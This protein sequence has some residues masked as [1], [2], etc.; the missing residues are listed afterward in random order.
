L[1]VTRDWRGLH[2]LRE[3]AAASFLR[4]D[5]DGAGF[6]VSSQS[7]VVL[8]RTVD[9]M[10]AERFLRQRRPATGRGD[11][12]TSWVFRAGEGE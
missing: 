10:E 9:A 4:V 7:G 1:S 12:R 8:F 11:W 5:H 3:R 2:R 6:V